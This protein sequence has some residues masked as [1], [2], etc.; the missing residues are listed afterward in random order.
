MNAEIRGRRS[1]VG[2]QRS[3][4]G[5]RHSPFPIRYSLLATRYSLFALLFSLFFFLSSHA[6]RDPFWP[7]GYEPPKPETETPEPAK[8]EPPPEPPK[9]KPPPPKPVTEA[10]WKKARATLAVSGI[11]R[12]TRPD[13]GETRALAMINRR[14]YTAGETLSITNEEIHFMWRIGSLEGFDLKLEQLQATRL[15]GNTTPSHGQ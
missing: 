11:T 6:A 2:G 13:T 5:D 3:E 9:P 4:V 12:S 10:D 1:E 15:S 8:P 7:I 14:L